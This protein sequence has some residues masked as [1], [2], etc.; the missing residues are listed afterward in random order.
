[1]VND[2]WRV[3]LGAIEEPLGERAPAPDTDGDVSMSSSQV[4]GTRRSLCRCAQCL[5]F[6]DH[7]YALCCLLR[8]WH[9]LF[10]SVC[11]RRNVIVTAPLAVLCSLAVFSPHQTQLCPSTDGTHSTTAT[12]RT[13]PRQPHPTAIRYMLGW[14]LYVCC[15]A[16]TA[17]C[18]SVLFGEDE[19][20]WN[21]KCS[22]NAATDADSSPVFLSSR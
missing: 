5:I 18:L 3:T 6:F 1:M 15:G 7:L 21:A 20:C 8:C 19:L 14:L 12:W 10:T 22:R 13:P 4:L 11:A 9:C 2:T 16:E 17:V